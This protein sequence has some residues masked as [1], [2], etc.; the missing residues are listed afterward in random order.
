MRVILFLVF[1]LSSVAYG[2]V[3]YEYMKCDNGTDI[4]VG[5]KHDTICQCSIGELDH[6][7]NCRCESEKPLL[8]GLSI[9]FSALALFILLMGIRLF[10]CEKQCD[11][12]C[13]KFYE[14]EEPDEPDKV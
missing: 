7:Y 12:F 8:L 4:Y 5:E 6:C 13:E 9:S 2:D 3:C 11:R 10:V 1:C 14:T